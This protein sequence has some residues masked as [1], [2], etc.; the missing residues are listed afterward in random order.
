MRRGSSRSRRLEIFI[1]A[2]RIR[3]GMHWSSG[4][5]PS[6]AALRRLPSLRAR[7]PPPTRCS[8]SP[9]PATTSS[10]LLIYG[11]TWTL[12][13]QTLK[14]FGIEARFVDPTDPEAFR[15]ATDGKTR[16][17]YAEILPNP[18]LNVFPIKEVADI[19][20]S[21]GVPLIAD[22]TA[23][24][25][26]AR[27]LEHGAAV[28]VYSATK[29]I[30]GHGTSIGGLIVD[31]GNFPWE[32]HADRFPLLTQPDEAYHGAIWTDAAKPLGPIA[33]ILRRRVKLLRDI[34]A[35]LSPFNAFQLI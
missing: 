5:P 29:Y 13:S 31:G 15:R 16:A 14:Q 27:P 2:S 35:A 12:F 21:L 26:I 4:S 7:R 28:V 1:P 23:T 20:R 34:G 3:R 24:P 19:G 22:N 30:G 10:P 11:G 9:R 17:Y 6:R 32:E 33:F 18:K 25:L 8:I